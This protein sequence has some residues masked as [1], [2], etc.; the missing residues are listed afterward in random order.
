MAPLIVLV[1]F[2]GSLINIPVFRESVPSQLRHHPLSMGLERYW[3]G[4]HKEVR[5]RII[6]INVGGFVVPILLV[7]YE[8]LLIGSQYPEGL[9]PLT[10]AVLINIFVL[11]T[12][13]AGTA[14]WHHT[15]RSCTWCDCRHLCHADS[16]QASSTCRLLLRSAGPDYWS[17]FDVP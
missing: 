4:M 7:V 11:F 12:W 3:P 10:I 17:W 14:N 8:V 13:R 9:L 5:E 15:T 2:F 16:T 1:M 6:A